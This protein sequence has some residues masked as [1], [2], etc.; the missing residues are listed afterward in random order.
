MGGGL[1]LALNC[2][3][4]I[5]A[6]DARFRMPAARLGLGYGFDGIK[7]FTEVVGVAHTADLFYSA[8]IFGAQD[9]LAIGLVKQVTSVEELAAVVDAYADNVST[10]APLTLAAAKRALLELRKAPQDRDLALVKTMVQACFASEDYKEGRKA[11]AE[12]RT[13]EFKNH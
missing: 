13:P 8:R 9:A 1:G 6:D 4:R 5:C 10:N 12:K 7:R 3:V 2:D 11:F